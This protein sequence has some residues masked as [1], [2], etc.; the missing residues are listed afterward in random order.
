MGE[1]GPGAQRILS[2]LVKDRATFVEQYDSEK[3]FHQWDNYVR[4]VSFFNRYPDYTDHGPGHVN[5]VVTLAAQLAFTGDGGPSK[6]P[7]TRAELF[8][9]AAAGFL[10]D[11]GMYSTQG[12]KI[13]DPGA[14][15][16]IHALL[17]RKRMLEERQT[18]FPNVPEPDVRLIGTIAAFHQSS[19]VLD[20]NHLR[21]LQAQAS[22]KG[23]TL[24]L[25]PDLKRLDEELEDLG[26][27]DGVTKLALCPE[28]VGPDNRIRMPILA[29]LLRLLD[30]SDIQ[31]TRAGNL[32]FL[33]RRI[34]KMANLAAQ[35]R[36]LKGALKDEATSWKKRASKEEERCEEAKGHYLKDF[37][38]ERTF[39]AGDSIFV[40]VNSPERVRE[41][42][43]L[44]PDSL[45]YAADTIER[46]AGK[47][48]FEE[49]NEYIQ[50]ELGVL[51]GRL[52]E[53][54]LKLEVKSYPVDE[55]ARAA[56]RKKLQAARIWDPGTFPGQ[57]AKLT[58]KEAEFVSSKLATDGSGQIAIL[59][60]PS[61]RGKRHFVHSLA[62]DVLRKQLKGDATALWWHT[63]D[64]NH[65][66]QVQAL[67]QGASSYLASCGEFAL[68]N[69]FQEEALA[70]EAHVNYFLAIMRGSLIPRILVLQYL[71]HVEKR[72]R[73]FFARTFESLGR[74]TILATTT[75]WPSADALQDYFGGDTSQLLVVEVPR[76]SRASGK[77]V[78]L[79]L[80]KGRKLA[81][82]AEREAFVERWC[83][84]WEQWGREGIFLELL[85]EA[86]T[87]GGWDDGAVRSLMTGYLSGHFAGQWRAVSNAPVYE[88][89]SSAVVA[90]RGA[91]FPPGRIAV[92]DKA[93]RA[94]SE[95]WDRSLARWEEAEGK[96][97]WQ[98]DDLP[99][100]F[101]ERPPG[102]PF[103]WLHPG[104]RI[105]LAGERAG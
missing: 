71:N 100:L 40:K 73:H 24:K 20:P 50:K 16:D 51:G 13:E 46:S 49:A 67:I 28:P 22:A 56:I 3:L 85:P 37:W 82:A 27:K 58:A 34:D 8:C 79:G 72:Y 7:L 23:K 83:N 29:A 69:I 59:F 42:M 1:L 98:A 88:A 4:R 96:D 91:D 87:E 68:A 86:L 105:V 53:A 5:S 77:E 99:R 89:V 65:G 97:P 94:V 17:S 57:S 66:S 54:G 55:A 9:L 70:T 45:R 10:H 31:I 32:D 84:F 103:A 15:R 95:L 44:V 19:T 12:D 52:A 90:A 33:V 92:P 14:I 18:L 21:Q 35:M 102:R 47:N 38:V 80:V 25:M 74:R 41:Q 26:I 78:L 81:S 39:I 36:D 11:I 75:R 2:H 43:T 62:N 93:Q 30:Q 101:S 61:G 60:G 48:F 64:R 63:I 104:L 6:P 76:P